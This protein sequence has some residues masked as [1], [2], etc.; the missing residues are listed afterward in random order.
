MLRKIAKSFLKTCRLSSYPVSFAYFCIYRYII[1]K[2]LECMFNYP[3]A[4]RAAL[5]AKQNKRKVF[6]LS[7]SLCRRC[8]NSL[9]GIIL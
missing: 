8:N 6:S 3:S 5:C 4:K 7:P 2:K 9:D 1:V